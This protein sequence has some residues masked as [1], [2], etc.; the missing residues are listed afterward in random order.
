MIPSCPIRYILQAGSRTLD[1]KDEDDNNNNDNNNKVQ[2]T[3]RSRRNI[4][5]IL[6]ETVRLGQK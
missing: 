5:N 3:G 1:K 2:W 6:L 4:E